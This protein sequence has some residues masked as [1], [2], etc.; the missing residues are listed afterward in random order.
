MK[1]LMQW[2]KLHDKVAHYI[3]GAIFGIAYALTNDVKILLLSMAIFIGKEVFDCY[4]KNPTGFDVP[5]ILSGMGGY[6]FINQILKV[7]I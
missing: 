3:V 1:Q 6:L 4:K 5:D 7:I 2:C